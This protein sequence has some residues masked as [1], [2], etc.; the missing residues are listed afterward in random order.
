MRKSPWQSVPMP[1]QI[2]LSAPVQVKEKELSLQ[3]DK[4][5]IHIHL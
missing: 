2:C 4:K 1:N 3:H 5:D